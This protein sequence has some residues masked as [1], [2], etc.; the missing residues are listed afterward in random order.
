M[1]RYPPLQHIVVSRLSNVT[2]LDSCK[3]KV[4]KRQRKEKR[5]ARFTIIIC[6]YS[7]MYVIVFC[8]LMCDTVFDI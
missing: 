3:T 8:I 7:F 5:K 4:D 1:A 6:I 2:Q